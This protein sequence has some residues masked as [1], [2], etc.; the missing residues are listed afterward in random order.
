MI[1]GSPPNSRRHVRYS[2]ATTFGAFD[3]SSSGRK[4]RPSRG[5]APKT[6]NHC[7]VTPGPEVVPQAR[8]SHSSH[9]F[10]WPSPRRRRPVWCRA[11]PRNPLATRR[12]P[13]GLAARADAQGDEPMGI[14]RADR[15]QQQ[16]VDRAEHRGVGGDAH[17]QREDGDRGEAA[18]PDQRADRIRDVLP[19]IGDEPPDDRVPAVVAAVCCSR[20]RRSPVKTAVRVVNGPTVGRTRECSCSRSKSR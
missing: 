8:R 19:R 13:S 9:P 11:C 3:T 12:C 17:S 5:R 4:V 15:M 14:L 18:M 20:N 7:H 2:S 16:G 6:S 1:E 10:R